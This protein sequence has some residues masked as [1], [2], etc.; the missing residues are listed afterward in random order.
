MSIDNF[1]TFRETWL[2]SRLF[3]VPQ[4]RKEALL[5]G[6][7]GEPLKS[8]SRAAV[9]PGNELGV[10]LSPDEA[11]CPFYVVNERGSGLIPAP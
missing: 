1:I 2:H 9:R 7:V 5:P 11:Y 8:K 3:C 4:A 10:A 6:H